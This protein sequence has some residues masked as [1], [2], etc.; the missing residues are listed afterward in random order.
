MSYILALVLATLLHFSP[1][2]TEDSRN[3]TWDAS[4]QGNHR[5]TSFVDIGGTLYSA[6]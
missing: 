2:A 4:T 3:C 6:R 5:G 1:C